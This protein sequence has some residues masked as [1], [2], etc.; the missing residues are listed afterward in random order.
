MIKT[1]SVQRET[2]LGQNPLNTW[3]LSFFR[4]VLAFAFSAFLSAGALGCQ[5]YSATHSTG[6]PW[7]VDRALSQQTN[8][9][10]FS[11]VG[12][13]VDGQAVC[14]G[15]ATVRPGVL[16]DWVKYYEQASVVLYLTDQGGRILEQHKLDYPAGL[17]VG[18][19]LEFRFEVDSPTRLDDRS[20]YISFG[21]F[22]LFAEFDSAGGKESGGRKTI[23]YEAGYQ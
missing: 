10:D 7:Q 2:I 13:V 4:L 19:A 6:N 3:F 18:K 8:V 23:R 9:F 16:P 17:P 20:F 21:Y 5:Q 15:I 22:M 14:R 12:E 11:Y 1:A